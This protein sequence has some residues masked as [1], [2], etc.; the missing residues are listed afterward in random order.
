MDNNLRNFGK[1]LKRARKKAGYKTQQNLADAL[2]EAGV[3]VTKDTVENWEQGVSSPTLNVFLLLCDFFHCSSDYLLDRIDEK[4]HDLKFICDY[5][6]LSEES[7]ELL[8]NIPAWDI[9]SNPW[10]NDLDYFLSICGKDFDFYL[11]EI[12]HHRK[13]AKLLQKSGDNFNEKSTNK[14]LKDQLAFSVY[15]F[16]HFCDDVPDKLFDTQGLL[17]DLDKKI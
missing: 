2:N 16:L 17:S 14:K 9:E 10:H 15:S 3:S 6:G 1:G 13:Y 8:R 7:V 12:R 11:S 4:N 5:T